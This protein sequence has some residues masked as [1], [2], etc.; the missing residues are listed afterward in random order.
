VLPPLLYGDDHAY[1]IPFTGSG[2]EESMAALTRDDL[3][4]FSATGCGPTTRASSWSARSR[5]DEIVPLLEKHFGRWS[6]PA[7]PPPVKNIGTNARPDA[8]RVFLVDQPGAIQANI[9]AG[10][11]VGSTADDEALDFDIANSVFG[12]TFT[13]RINMNLREDKGWSY[14][15]SSFAMGAKGQRP[16]MISAP[17]RS[18]APPTRSW[19]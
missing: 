15:V 13:S 10:L 11:L 8:P 3:L 1:G 5:M 19:S 18:T 12:G 4:A 6:A 16:W 7:T 17:V 2:T 14:G 9:M